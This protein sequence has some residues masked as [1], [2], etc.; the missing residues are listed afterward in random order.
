MH[1]AVAL[2]LVDFT[3]LHELPP[4]KTAAAQSGKPIALVF[5]TNVKGAGC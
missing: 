1:V 4:A 5:L 2:L 3:W